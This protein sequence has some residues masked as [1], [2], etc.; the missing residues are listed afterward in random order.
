MLDEY[1]KAT[2]IRPMTWVRYLDEIF[3]IWHHDEKSLKHFINFCGNFNTSRKM[4]SNIKFETN[5]SSESVNFLDFQVSTNENKI[6]TSLYSKLT[7][8]HLYLNSKSCHP[9]LKGSSY[10]FE[11]SVRK[12]L[13]SF[14]TPTK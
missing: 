6:K 13:T 10:G 8:S 12:K 11:E 9:H 3:F 7:D 2:H 1:E 5:M 14:F 4:K